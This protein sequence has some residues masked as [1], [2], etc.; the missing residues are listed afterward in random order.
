MI[1]RVI[2][3]LA[4]SFYDHP[5]VYQDIELA[6]PF[7]HLKIALVTDHFT[8]ECLAIESQI[9]CLTPS[10]YRHVLQT[11]KP[12]FIFIESA[13]HGAG[14]SWR[15]ELAKQPRWLRWSKLR[16]IQDLITFAKKRGIP[17]VFWNKDDGD[18]FDD[19]I[20]IAVQ[21]DYVFT[22]DAN[23]IPRYRERLPA[24]T[25]AE[26]LMM[27]YQPAFHSFQGFNFSRKEA[28]F[29]GS[30]YRRILNERRAFLDLVFESAGKANLPIQVYDRNYGRLSHRFAFGFPRLP[31]LHIHP[32]VAQRQTAS[33]YQDHVISINVNS[34]TS[35]E[36]MV[37]RRLL[38]ILACGGIVV[39][40]PSRAITKHFADF[41]HI[42]ST[43][44]EG[45]AL[46]TRLK[47]G[48]TTQDFEMAKAGTDY[49]A[50]HHTWAHRLEQICRT[51]RVFGR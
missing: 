51:V 32:S 10:N 26:V 23:C 7:K 48:P 37:S 2:R 40:N 29:V 21:C 31:Q 24:D 46:F 39:S 34:V 16:A 22:T 35:S 20:E 44:E 49:V 25:P 42:V 36:T 6:G 9:Q 47:E 33:L 18:Y 19:F 43:Q 28:C 8:T 5:K 30:Y 1:A 12:D 3:K 27:P 14:G 4:N 50:Q 13:F 45:I 15:Y 11:W 38:E 17:V 41:C